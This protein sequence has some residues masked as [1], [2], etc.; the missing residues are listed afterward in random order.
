MLAQTTPPAEPSS[1]QTQADRHESPAAPRPLDNTGTLTALAAP[2]A[3][4]RDEQRQSNLAITDSLPG[5][6]TNTPGSLTP[7]VQRPLPAFQQ[8]SPRGQPPAAASHHAQGPQ[9]PVRPYYGPQTAWPQLMDRCPRCGFIAGQPWYP[10]STQT[11]QQQSL[12]P[13]YPMTTTARQNRLE[14]MPRNYPVG[15][16]PPAP[17]HPDAHLNVPTAPPYNSRPSNPQPARPAEISPMNPPSPKNPTSFI[18]YGVAASTV[19]MTEAVVEAD[20]STRYRKRRESKAVK[21]RR[22]TRDERRDI[23]LMRRL[24]YSYDVIARFLGTT[25]SAVSY[26]CR[27]GTADTKHH[28][29][30]RRANKLPPETMDKMV[31]YVGDYLAK[32]RA[33]G[34][35]KKTGKKKMTPLTYSMIRD[36]VFKDGN[37]NIDPE[38]KIS[39]DALKAILN[40]KGLWLR[41]P[42]SQAKI[43][44]ARARGKKQWLDKCAKEAAEKARAE[45][46][47]RGHIITEDQLAAAREH[48]AREGEESQGYAE[49]VAEAEAAAEAEHEEMQ[50]QFSATESVL[51]VDEDMND[52]HE[53]ETQLRTAIQTHPLRNE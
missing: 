36:A 19:P 47:S 6:S 35:D 51:D 52:D 10:Q 12:P 17:N 37:G 8:P 20:G 53:K 7:S 25:I 44:E 30:G 41:M 1:H 21:H 29:A 27:Q 13:D 23:L 40:K 5:A 31:N 43:E 26:T 38:L 45:A 39:D 15:S 11:Q 50:Q 4:T 22:L 2:P 48:G 46:A 14:Q 42:F 34:F 16:G 3:L 24:G 28:M 49:A 9:Q 33:A 32:E 18:G